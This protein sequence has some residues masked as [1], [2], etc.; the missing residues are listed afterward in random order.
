MFTRYRMLGTCLLFV[1]SMSWAA[2][3]SDPLMVIAMPDGTQ[4]T[5]SGTTTYYTRLFKVSL[6]NVGQQPVDLTNGCFKVHDRSGTSYAL[7]IADEELLNGSLKPGQH[8]QGKMGFSS[9]QRDVYDADV[10]R[11]DTQCP[12]K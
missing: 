6:A 8:K 12:S 9:L 7:D 2:M 3:P 10:I 4:A 1:S 11:F 5:T